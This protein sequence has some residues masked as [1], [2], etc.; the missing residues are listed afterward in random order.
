MPQP[1][2]V[3]R[4][5]PEG[6][7]YPNEVAAV[8]AQPTLLTSVE[9]STDGR[10]VPKTQ[11]WTPYWRPLYR[12]GNQDASR[13]LAGLAEIW[14]K[15][16][17]AGFDPSLSQEYCFRYFSL[18]DSVLSLAS[19]RSPTWQSALRLVLGFECFGIKERLCGRHVVAAGTASERNPCYLLAKLRWPNKPD[20]IRLLPLISNAHEPQQPFMRYRRLPVSRDPAMSILT[21]LPRHPASRPGALKLLNTLAS[22]FGASNDPFVEQRAERIW[23]Y[24]FQPIMQANHSDRRGSNRIEVVDVGAGTGAL[25]AAICQRVLKWASSEGFY[26]RFRLWFIDA[27]SAYPE[28]AFRTAPFRNHIES[29]L[30]LAGDYR[31]WL[32]Q[33]QPMPRPSGPR[34]AL[35]SKV[36]DM[37]SGFATCSFRTHV[38]PSAVANSK[39]LV[40]GGVL[41]TRCLGPN[42]AGSQALVVSTSR[43]AVAE[44]HTWPLAS[45]SE[46]FRGLSMVSAPSKIS[47]PHGNVWLPL[48]VFNHESLTTSDGASALSRLLEHCDYLVIEDEDLRPKD[49]LEHRHTFLLDNVVAEDISNVMGLKGNY[50]Y[51][52]W[53]KDSRAPRL[54][55]AAVW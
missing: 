15:Y 14:C 55:G 54:G 22:N 8:L 7:R 25:T 18:L 19:T 33:R 53:G 34:I 3:L 36:F 28:R 10:F 37:S 17:S 6:L 48:R 38:L 42:G 5:R 45:S 2:I 46:Y 44:G 26:P 23:R 50:A 30:V 32:A 13:A 11:D 21:Y 49:L 51:V 29:A 27:S 1:S 47:S 24:A 43:I 35:A 52:L 12:L 31:T 39:K 9:A 16:V 20:D 4:A 41:P 40:G